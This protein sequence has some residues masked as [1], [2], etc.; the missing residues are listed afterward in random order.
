MVI[1]N[2]SDTI[3]GGKTKAKNRDKKAKARRGGIFT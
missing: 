1:G 3:G 2:K